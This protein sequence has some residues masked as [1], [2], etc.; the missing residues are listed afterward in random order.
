MEYVIMFVSIASSCGSVMDE[1]SHV[2]KLP[3]DVFQQPTLEQFH[4]DVCWIRTNIYV[5]RSRTTNRLG[6][7]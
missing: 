5:Y 2:P 1:K 3:F 6:S 7:N 4:Q